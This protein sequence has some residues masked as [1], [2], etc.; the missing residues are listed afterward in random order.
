MAKSSKHA[1]RA[2]RKKGKGKT[3][4][5]IN[6]V[7]E[8]APSKV[9]RAKVKLSLDRH[10][11]EGR[12][13]GSGDEMDLSGLGQEAMEKLHSED[14]EDIN[15]EDAFEESDKDEFAGSGFVRKGAK[16]GA[17]RRKRAVSVKEVDLNEDSDDPRSASESKQDEDEDM[18][19]GSDEFFDVLDVFDGQEEDAGMSED[20][21]SEQVEEEDGDDELRISAS[22]SEDP[23]PEALASLETF[24]SNLDPTA[25]HKRKPD[26]PIA[27]SN[28]QKRRRIADRTEAGEENEF[29]PSTKLLKSA[30]L[31]D[32]DIE[33]TEALKMAHLT[34][35]EVAARR[36]ELR[37]MRELTFRADKKAKR[38][39][40]IKSKAYRRLR[41]KQRE[42]LDG[43]DE[44]G[45]AGEANDEARLKAEAL[46]AKER[47]TLR[48]KNTGKWANAMKGRQG[49]D[50]DQR[51]AIT[52]MLDRG[53]K[54]RRRIHGENS[55][56]EG[57][58]RSE[59]DEEQDEG[60]IKRNAFEEL[61]ALGTEE[62]IDLST[63]KSKSVFN[64]KFMRDAAARQTR[65]ADAQVEALQNEL[66]FGIDGQEGEDEDEDDAPSAETTMLQRT[67]RSGSLASDTSSVTL[68]STDLLQ[69]VPVPDV[70]SSPSISIST[71]TPTSMPIPNPW[72]Q[73]NTSGPSR[74][75]NEVRV[76]KDADALAKSA[77]K[78]KKD[79][80]EHQDERERARDDAVLNIDANAFLT[81]PGP[82]AASAPG[83]KRKGTTAKGVA[84]TSAHDGSD[85]SDAA[86]E[87]DEQERTVEKKGEQTGKGV[88][89]FQQ[90]DL[91]ALAFA[92]DNVVQAFEEAKRHEAEAD[93]P[94]EVDTTLPGWGAWG[95]TG[96]TPRPPKSHLLK[97]IPGIAPSARADHAK[98]HLIISEKRDK[99]TN[100]YRVCEL[101]H[102]YT[103]H[104]Q[105][106]RR[107]AMPL[108]TEWNT[109]VGF[110]QG[111]LPRVVK[112]M[113]TVID[114]L[115][116]LF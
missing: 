89:A 33:H 94:K 104:A 95:G 15:S 24:L 92:G 116:K 59:S 44:D 108:G 82:P 10:E 26:P 29:G 83:K 53:E 100:K 17:A 52:E 1:D 13:Y 107:M 76:H 64:M 12:Q 58:E 85:D 23:S 70:P 19:D 28:P 22:D 43:A 39:A 71:P 74:K 67:D 112:K 34:V 69:D 79:A 96:T 31:R 68:Q 27:D 84:K 103:S 93:A 65:E 77:N 4:V 99:K 111:T 14:D 114:P 55:D 42:R 54:L 51:Q 5:T 66:R 75:R 18:D 9:R 21:D 61:T 47:A 38:I 45:D 6:D 60:T 86:S 81:V 97:S 48:H 8:Y 36:A 37:V 16:T 7:Y 30:Q 105:F 91:V 109:R 46:R 110:Q 25:A 35:D 32:E 72:L 113:G 106:E 57:S 90:R 87:L 41:K 98:P 80:N 20:D 40:K 62:D 50:Q 3:H 11:T 88:Q 101:P 78:L 73:T 63:L 115:E 49:L 56:D 102:P 2:R